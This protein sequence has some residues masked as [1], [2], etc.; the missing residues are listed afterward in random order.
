VIPYSFSFQHDS[1]KISDADSNV[2]WWATLALFR[3]AQWLDGAKAMVDARALDSVLSLLESEN[4]DI[5]GWACEIVGRLVIHEPTAPTVLE[6][7]PCAT[8]VSLMRWVC[9]LF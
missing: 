7:K 9:V 6:P 3:I 8:L 5:R 1:H 4:P 2:I